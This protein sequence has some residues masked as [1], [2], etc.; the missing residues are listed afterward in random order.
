MS[1]DGLALAGN[2]AYVANGYGGLSDTFIVGRDASFRNLLSVK[3]YITELTYGKSYRN[4]GKNV[5]GKTVY[6]RDVIDASSFDFDFPVKTKFVG[7]NGKFVVSSTATVTQNTEFNNIAMDVSVAKGFNITG[8]NISFIDC[9]INYNFDAVADVG[10]IQSIL[11]NVNKAC[12]FSSTASGIGNTTSRVNVNI[13]K[14]R[15]TSSYE[16]RYAFV[17]FIATNTSHYHENIFIDDNS[18]ITSAESDDKRTAFA[19]TT[20]IS[21]PYSDFG[22]LGTRLVNASMSNNFCNKNQ[23][24]M[25]SA[26]YND[27]FKVVNM[28]VPVS[29]KINNNICGAICYLTQQDQANSTFNEEYKVYD[30]DNLL[31]IAGNNCK[32]I[33]CGTNTGF[34]NVETSF[35]RVIYDILSGASIYSASTIITKN[36][37][38]WIQIGVKNPTSYAYEV[39]MLEIS[40]NKINAYVSSFLDDYYSG[41]S[42]VNDGLIVDS[43]SGT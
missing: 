21:D 37:C 16:D 42:S 43:I 34:I 23:L 9:D 26:A 29:V 18:I 5:F 19:I 15:F 3:N 22:S 7:D 31:V 20:D 39:P 1:G 36:N 10:Y 27:S 40:S 6:V 33:Y 25:I 41:I 30:K 8:N 24:L 2:Y 28:F 4:T 13:S 11:S 38:S 17:S 35:N 14:N 12:I 32:L